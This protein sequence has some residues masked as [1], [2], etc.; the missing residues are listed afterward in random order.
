VRAHLASLVHEFR[1]HAAQTAVVVHRGNRSYPTTYGEIANLAGRFAAELDRRH[2]LPGERVILWGTNSA[3]WIAAFFGCLLRGVIAVPLDAAGSPAFAQRILNDVAPKLI[4]A[5]QLL[6]A[7]LNTNIP[8]LHLATLTNH[9]PLEPNFTVSPAVTDQTPFQIIFTSGTTSDPKGIVHTHRNVLASLQPIEDEI[10]KYRRYERIVHPL[11]FLHTLPLSHVF[12]QFMGLWIPPL[13]AAEVHFVDQL[14]A[15]RTIDLI[16]RERIS[17]LIAVPRVLHLLRAHLLSQFRLTAAE[18]EQANTLSPWK[19]W[20]RFRSVHRA[21]GWK[22]WAIISGGATLPADLERFWNQLGLALIQGYGMTETAALITL[23]HPFRVAQGTIGKALPG[24]E[25]RL[26][27]EGEILV[28]GDMLA[29]S[30]W[31]SGKMHPREGDWLATGDLAAESTSG[32]LRFLGRRNDVIVTAAGMNIHPAD[33]EAAMNAQPNIRGCVVVPCEITSG[34]EPVA[35]VLS[36]AN[37]EE[38]Q[39]AVTNANQTLASYQQIRRIQRWPQLN[40]PYTS[41]GKLLRRDI[42]Q[43]ACT[44]LL[45]QQS[46]PLNSPETDVLLRLIAAVTGE[47][48]S[49]PNDRLRLSEDLHLDSLGR[50]QLQS[51]LEQQLQLELNEDAIAKATTL[52]HLRQLIHNETAPH[53]AE[54]PKPSFADEAQTIPSPAPITKPDSPLLRHLYPHW[55]WLWPVKA[56]RIAFIEL[57][58]RPLIW[59][60]AAPR[61]V[62]A[63]NPPPQGPLLLIANHVTAYDG[64]LILYALP[65]HLR[66]QTAIAMSGEMLFDLRHG[67]N[68]SNSLLNLLAPAGYWLITALFNVFPLP[69]LRGFQRSFEYAGEAMDK[70]YSVLIFPEGTRS[71]DAKLHPFRPGIGLLAQESRIPIL[72]IALIGLDQMKKTGW[73]RSGHLEIRLGEP[74]PTDN[75]STPT[76]LTQ[77]FE[78]TLR[79]LSSL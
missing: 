67:Q 70:G 43:W 51:E 21:L 14:E 77:K 46:Q 71:P 23:N 57:I 3:E 64:A 59:L 1:Q 17:V 4:V 12:G 58:M 75:D 29:A 39:T 37:D 34:A 66:H 63:P 54:S 18:L 28:R 72:P 7:S 78:A 76:D 62:R 48:I 49:H 41:T 22:F 33:L 55:P 42:S 69:R 38:L 44:T 47:P 16:H 9:L 61:V 10:A 5:D 65:R 8:Q 53:I 35:V 11:R 36:S 40:F 52:G 73:L 13:L 50:V 2:I 31:Q 6:L 68:Q 25:V 74:I 27:S 26:S 24:R 19:R 32:D 60:L 79:R 30:T 45:H 56:A 15:R 20:W